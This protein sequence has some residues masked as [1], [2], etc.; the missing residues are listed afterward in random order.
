MVPS[1]LSAL[2]RTSEWTGDSG[3]GTALLIIFYGEGSEILE[4][5]VEI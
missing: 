3:Q 2:P 5:E 1:E 4:G